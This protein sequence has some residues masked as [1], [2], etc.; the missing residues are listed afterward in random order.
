MVMICARHTIFFSNPKV[1]STALLEPHYQKTAERAA[2]LNFKYALAIQD[3]TVLNFTSHKAKTDIGRVGTKVGNTEQYGLIQHSTLLVT[4]QN[5]PLGLIDLH[6]FHNDEFDTSIPKHLRA[7]EDK[8]SGY[9]VAALNKTRT[10]LKNLDKK[11][12]TVTDR[13]GDFFEFLHE[14]NSHNDLF[15]IR[16]IT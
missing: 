13:E 4:D 1:S 16:A 7:L 10:R 14:L 11:I 3:D 8:R 5:E 6:H 2:S 9:W 15:V 12:I